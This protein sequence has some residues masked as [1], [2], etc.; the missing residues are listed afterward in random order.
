MLDRIIKVALSFALC[1]SLVVVGG[2]TKYASQDDENTL[3]EAS[4]AAVS[5]EKEL[6]KVVK[7]RKQLEKELSQKE[8]E[9]SDAKAELE[10]VKTR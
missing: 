5:A 9:L 8:G 4:Q 2:C 6:A 1:I 7:E 3:N 10:N